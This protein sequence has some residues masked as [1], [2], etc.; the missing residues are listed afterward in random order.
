ML[1]Y[2]ALSFWLQA[3]QALLTGAVFLYVWVT[4][5]QKANTTAIKEVHASLSE[6]INKVDDRLIQ[7]EK[8]IEYAPSRADFDKM[9]SRINTISDSVNHVEGEL[10]QMNNT[11]QMINDHLINQGSRP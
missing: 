1:D 8:D 10:K 6:E 5:R 11:L 2:K 9:S 4:S 3:A 7:V